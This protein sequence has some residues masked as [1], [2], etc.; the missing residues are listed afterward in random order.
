M[1]KSISVLLA[2]L[3]CFGLMSGAIA[4]SGEASG[5]MRGDQM[6]GLTNDE[7]SVIVIQNG[8]VA[9]KPDF[10]SFELADGGK[11]AADGISG[12]RVKG[13]DDQ[14][15]GIYVSVDDDDAPF[16]LGGEEDF[17]EVEGYGSFNS[18]I[19]VNGPS[20]DPNNECWNGVGLTSQGGWMTVDNVY[21]H[22]EGFRAS[23]IYTPEGEHE[24][25]LIVK[26]STLIADGAEGGFMPDFKL[27]VGS[28]RD[29]L[30]LGEDIWLYNNTFIAR[31]WGAISHD[32]NTTDIQLYSVNNYAETYDGGYVLYA[33]N[34]IENFMYGSKFVS[35]Q[36]GIFIMGSGTALFDGMD[37]ADKAAM[38][39]GEDLDYSDSV[40]GNGRS[41]LVGGCNAVVFHVNGGVMDPGNLIVRHATLSTMPEDV[42]SDFGHELS[43]DLDSY[44]LS[45]IKF[46][47]AWFYMESCKGSLITTRS[48]GG[49]IS[50][51]DG[52]ELK[53]ANGVLVQ[54]ML[55]Y[56][57]DAGNIYRDSGSTLELKDVTV[58]IETP[59]SGDILHTDYQRNMVIN[60]DAD[61][62]GKVTTGSIT[63]WN[64]QWTEDGLAAL[65]EQGGMTGKFELND[66]V[67]AN[68]RSCLVREEDTSAYTDVFGVSMTV[69]KGAAWTVKGESS[70]LNLSVEKGAQ[71][72]AGEYYVNCE[73]GA[74][75]YLDKA[76]GEKLDALDAGDYVNIV[77]VEGESAALET[78]EHDG[79]LYVLL[80]DL[81]DMLGLGEKQGEE[82]P[83]ADA[84]YGYQGEF[85]EATASP[86]AVNTSDE[87]V[88]DGE[89]LF[90]W[91][92]SAVQNS[93]T[94]TVVARNSYIRGDTE[95]STE[96]LAG[97]PGNL[98]I[99]GNIR[100]TLALGQ[101][102]G[103]Y[104]NSTIVSRNWAAL[105]TD[106]A[107]PA[108]EDG[109]K[110]LSLYAY[111]TEAIT[112]DGGYGA[113]SDLFCNLYSY[114]SHIQAAEIGI[115]S[116]TYGAVTVGTIADGEENAELAA[117]LTDADKALRGDKTLGSI[118][119]GG[120]NAIMLHSVNLPPYW[121]YEGYS[122][123]ES[124]LHST[125]VSVKNSV[126]RTD[127]SLDKGVTYEAGKQ[128]YIDHTMGSVILIKSTN[129]DMTL[130]N[131]EVV[132]DAAGTGY[133]VQTVY[134]NDTMF[135]NAVPDGEQY[136]G[137]K[138]TMKDM[139]VAGDI[140]H[141]DYQ[142]DF[143][144]TL[145]NAELTGAMNEY[146]CEHW[147]AVSAAEGFTAYC[148]D[149]SYATHH[150][151]Y[152]TLADGAVWNVT[153]ESVLSGLVIGEG[154]KLNGT[155]TV[156]GVEVEAVPGEYTGAIVITK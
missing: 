22:T 52:A 59:V 147:N 45:P 73:F 155:L 77:L 118:I 54:T 44:L 87:M 119:E 10:G 50:F 68:I 124:P 27:M 105:S 137:V 114:G 135:M 37:Q 58:N 152:V 115:I 47:E 80:S 129:I 99:G 132:P 53:A 16:T 2:L 33:L 1:K 9:T 106:G 95:A 78:V 40:T 146:D 88:L 122:Q 15:N 145:E 20:A 14:S 133:L 142:R 18:V 120:R 110:E 92:G 76:T 75:G 148:L 81:V 143:Y 72:L 55:A 123:E 51:E 31:D 111:G 91:E 26:N 94:S 84:A 61:Y 6:Y 85:D 104:I 62:E 113:Y 103:Y 108:L 82:A 100:T 117:K 49:N 79:A 36:Y 56:D 11:L 153:G 23:P 112:Q 30:L 65:L 131:S 17:Y 154:C 66:E 21:F 96:P 89:Q 28:A 70:V 25:N 156:D 24:T 3:L 35:P 67:I 64:D 38:Q 150:G 39:Y 97:N 63:A 138:I 86:D 101:G 141:E 32:K 136:P 57:S 7:N 140:A 149:A 128:A 93:G 109:E 134:N 102:Q 144:L 74:D 139:T 127:M 12:I 60:V 125:A 19:E 121:V 116:G 4:A 8:T 43:F 48:H 41:L 46:G 83:A 5:A 42:K 130:E 98:L 29:T 151:L 107:E 126:L 71:V 13:A 90:V 34:G 69:A